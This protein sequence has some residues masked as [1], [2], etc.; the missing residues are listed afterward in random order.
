MAV[1]VMPLRQAYASSSGGNR[2]GHILPVIEVLNLLELGN[3]QLLDLI[4]P[5]MS[6]K[7][8]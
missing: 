3:E 2:T 6:K 4:S 5:L 7:S 1:L 8:M